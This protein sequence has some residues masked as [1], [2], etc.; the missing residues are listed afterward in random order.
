MRVYLTE[1]GLVEIYH[2]DP[3]EVV[4]KEEFQRREEINSLKAQKEAIEK[5]LSELEETQVTKPEDGEQEQAEISKEV[6][7]ELPKVYQVPTRNRI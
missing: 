5:R 3:D 1:N 6:P 2:H 7:L 4:T